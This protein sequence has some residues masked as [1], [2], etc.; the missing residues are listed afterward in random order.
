MLFLFADSPRQ[1]Q[2]PRIG[3]RTKRQRAGGRRQRRNLIFETAHYIDLIRREITCA[4]ITSER[5][6]THKARKIDS[7]L[8]E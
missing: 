7:P 3:G 6:R 5:A 8:H 2:R 4:R 1:R